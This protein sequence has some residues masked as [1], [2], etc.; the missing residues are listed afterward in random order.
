MSYYSD[1]VNSM[2]S[3]ELLTGAG[4]VSVTTA[5]TYLATTGADAI[6]LA[7]AQI[8]QLK[9]IS[10]ASTNNTATLNSAGYEEGW[11]NITFDAV[12]EWVILRYNGRAWRV[13]ASYGATINTT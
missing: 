3:Y 7:A 8:S 6:T 9:M 4:A 10:V 12:G 1:I 11:T 2:H 13:V 5:V